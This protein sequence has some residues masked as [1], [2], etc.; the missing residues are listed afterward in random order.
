MD[1]MNDI[2]V[3]NYEDMICY[4]KAQTKLDEATIC[5]VLD[6]ETEYM[7]MAGIIAEDCIAD[8]EN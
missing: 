2:P 7:R 8:I 5:A 6:L 4:I 3:L 1:K